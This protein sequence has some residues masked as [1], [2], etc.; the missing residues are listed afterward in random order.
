MSGLL[1]C[2]LS[3]L[4]G[5]SNNNN[6]ERA[7]S[8]TKRQ[9]QQ[10]ENASN[11]TAVEASIT[12]IQLDEMRLQQ[13]MREIDEARTAKMEEYA[14]A[15]DEEASS[16]E[17]TSLFAAVSRLNTDHHRRNDELSSL[18]KYRANIESQVE[19]LR[20]THKELDMS[21][22]ALMALYDAIPPEKKIKSQIVRAMR[23]QEKLIEHRDRIRDSADD[24]ADM[25]N[26]ANNSFNPEESAN[27]L[28]EA[29]MKRKKAKFDYNNDVVRLS[30]G[31]EEIRNAMP[32][33]SGGSGGGSA[34]AAGYTR[35]DVTKPTK[36]ASAS[37]S[38][39]SNSSKAGAVTRI[40]D[41]T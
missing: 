19:G 29:F 21:D 1:S 23:N 30:E 33:A 20:S 24:A 2:L 10:E 31:V 15:V 13:Q 4:G 18:V 27:E 36:A 38:S 39:S 12:D 16:S 28:L 22:G 34:G 6:T 25:T 8:R 32:A 35:L 17:T 5:G 40:I 41:T 14:R 7:P 37:S 11:F 3:C 26:D 9:I